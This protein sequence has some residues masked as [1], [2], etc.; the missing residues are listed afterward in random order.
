MCT[1]LPPPAY[2]L[3]SSSSTCC[4]SPPRAHGFLPP[5]SPLP[6]LL[7]L[8]RVRTVPPSPSLKRR[9]VIPTG[10]RGRR[11]EQEEAATDMWGPTVIDLK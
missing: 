10:D 5:P 9:S 2:P 8:P 11:G 4:T 1:D 3:S 7:P 6:P